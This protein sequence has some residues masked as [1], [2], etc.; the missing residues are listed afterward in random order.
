MKDTK[1][2]NDLILLDGCLSVKN[3]QHLHNFNIRVSFTQFVKCLFK[4]SHTFNKF[5]SYEK[6]YD[7]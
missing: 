3:C 1:I 5:I 2:K 4:V 7:I 6:M